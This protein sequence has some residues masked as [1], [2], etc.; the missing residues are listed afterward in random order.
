MYFPAFGHEKQ[1]REKQSFSGL[2]PC[3]LFLSLRG[4]VPL[5]FAVKADLCFETIYGMWIPLPDLWALRGGDHTAHNPIRLLCRARPAGATDAM[6][7]RQK[8]PVDAPDRDF[9][10]QAER[11]VE[12]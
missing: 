7:Y 6:G 5:I 12:M 11:L 1:S 9:R 3:G 10:E 4:K 8:R 2:F